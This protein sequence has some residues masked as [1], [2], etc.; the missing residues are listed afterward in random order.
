MKMRPTGTLHVPKYRDNSP[1]GTE[2]ISDTTSLYKL[3][4]HIEIEINGRRVVNDIFKLIFM[5]K[6]CCIFIQISMKFAP[7]GSI[8][9]M[10]ALVHINQWWSIAYMGQSASMS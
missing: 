4:Q 7:G 2:F 3:S 6:N 8:N 9:N 1:L 10:P 5:H